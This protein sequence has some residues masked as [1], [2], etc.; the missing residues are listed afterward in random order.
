MTL[1]VEQSDGSHL[2]DENGDK[3]E[4]TIDYHSSSE[5]LTFECHI[6]NK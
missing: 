4:Y 6:F 2:L 1:Y 5:D 3:I